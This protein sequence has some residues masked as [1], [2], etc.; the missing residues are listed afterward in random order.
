MG[1]EITTRVPKAN[2]TGK[3]RSNPSVEIDTGAEF[4]KTF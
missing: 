4:E 2:E 3:I 1:T